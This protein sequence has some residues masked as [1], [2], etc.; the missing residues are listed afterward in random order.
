MIKIMK[1]VRKEK[2]MKKEKKKYWIIIINQK[3]NHI[4]VIL[5]LMP[6]IKEIH[7]LN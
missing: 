6:L 3:M 7:L 4:E 2:E 5:W 1:K